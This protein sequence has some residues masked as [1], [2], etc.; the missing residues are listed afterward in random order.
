MTSRF[1]LLFALTLG[2]AT[3]VV[4]PAAHAQPTAPGTVQ[5][6]VAQ[7]QRAAEVNLRTGDAGRALVF[8]DALLHRD[9]RDVTALLIRAHALRMQAQYPAAQTAACY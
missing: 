6:S 5:L 2:A 4:A 7:M 3:W 8:A 9:P 1:R